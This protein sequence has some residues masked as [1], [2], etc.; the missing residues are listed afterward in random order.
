M[1]IGIRPT[2]S[3]LKS[4]EWWPDPYFPVDELEANVTR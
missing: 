2:L 1:K 3:I 4:G